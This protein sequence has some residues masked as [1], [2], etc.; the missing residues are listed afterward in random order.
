M[1]IL[2]SSTS[3]AENSLMQSLLTSNQIALALGI[4]S[5]TVSVLVRNGIIP[6]TYVQDYK[7][8]ELRFDPY[9]IVK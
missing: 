5:H 2:K 3:F 8:K 7:G 6:H 1:Q 9:L 4:N